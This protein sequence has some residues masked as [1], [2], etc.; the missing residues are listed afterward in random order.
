MREAASI[1][2]LRARMARVFCLGRPFVA[3][4]EPQRPIGSLI[5]MNTPQ[6]I[7]ALST[8]VLALAACSGG[9]SGSGG[10]PEGAPTE[11]GGDDR[12]AVTQGDV[13]ALGATLGDAWGV[14]C[15]ESL[16]DMAGYPKIVCPIPDDMMTPGMDSNAVSI[17][18][19]TEWEQADEFEA[20]YVMDGE[21]F[22]VGNG[23]F[24]QAPTP[25]IAEA[26]ASEL[27]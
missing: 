27:E 18:T 3:T 26:A 19:F 24:V 7:V 15:G 10:D 8:L 22:V 17:Q 11:A 14:D 6:R 1:R 2:L 4:M 20:S 21:G 13:D 12:G 25:E 9:G 5:S 23:W 16:V